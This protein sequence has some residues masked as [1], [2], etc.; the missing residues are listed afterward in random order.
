M[1]VP[2]GSYIER[3]SINCSEL[4]YSGA[5]ATF[6][7]GIWGLSPLELLVSD[8]SNKVKI[9]DISNDLLDGSKS[10]ADTILSAGLSGGTNITSGTIYLEITL[11]ISLN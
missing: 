4:V 8:I 1:L 3:L 2:E 5:S 6:S 7:F 10:L 11:K 9:F